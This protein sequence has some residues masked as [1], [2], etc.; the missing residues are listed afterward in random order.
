MSQYWQ[1]QEELCSL[2]HNAGFV[3]DMTVS[4]SMRELG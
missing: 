4:W 3:R 2:G 1:T